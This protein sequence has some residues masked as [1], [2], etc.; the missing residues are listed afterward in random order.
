MAQP[1]SDRRKVPRPLGGDA[2]RSP[3]AVGPGWSR[4]TGEPSTRDD[5]EATALAPASSARQD[6][7]LEHANRWGLTTRV[8]A[9]AALRSKSEAETHDGSPTPPPVAV[10][11][12]D[13]THARKR[14]NVEAPSTERAGFIH[15]VSSLPRWKRWAAAGAVGLTTLFGTTLLRKSQ[16][17]AIAQGTLVARL[18]AAPPD[19]KPP[20]TPPLGDKREGSEAVATADDSGRADTSA[21]TLSEASTASETSSS[22]HD[23]HVWLDGGVLHLPRT[24]KPRD[25][26]YDLV[27]HFHGDVKIVRE[28]IE[29][30]GIN[31]A[32]AIIN[33]GIS[34]GPYQNTYK[35]PGRFERLLARIEAGL[36]EKGFRHLELRRLALTAW[37]GGYGAI[38]SILETRRAPDAENDPLDAIMVF[39][40]IHTGF[41]DNDKKRLAELGVL[42]FLRAAKAAA[43]DRILFTM[44]HSE[45]DPIAYA[46][47]TQCAD[48]LLASV[49]HKAEKTE[50]PAPQ[51]LR[52]KASAKSI[53]RH[54]ELK[55]TFDTRVGSFHVLGY[56]GNTPEAH[57]AHLHQ[58]AAIA[59]PELA[60][61]WA[62]AAPP[63]LHPIESDEPIARKLPPTSVVLPRP[64]R[65]RGK[66]STKTA[67][68]ASS[69]EKG[70]REK[71]PAQAKTS[72]DERRN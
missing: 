68:R 52:L 20:M 38:E 21:P 39:D 53:G 48:L 16:E 50:G 44:T 11:L 9:P 47:T 6:R 15:T 25:G 2:G 17:V 49:G 59:L 63:R 5:R 26:G 61:R 28:S 51:H 23:G 46:S 4:G 19:G 62:K 32:V 8:I 33:W 56:R 34:S 42:S 22:V 37:S 18:E 29:T 12:D 10:S 54:T 45:V 60:A 70:P 67:A 65:L 43:N 1:P 30:A 7:G 41:L 31:A 64:S 13:G 55:P 27:I 14:P 57:A 24:F 66:D 40:G 36:A 72:R 58:M 71:A 3:S 35:E 69:E